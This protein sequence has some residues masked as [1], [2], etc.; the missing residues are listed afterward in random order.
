MP[1]GLT[2]A[3]ATYQR[4]ME[5]CLQGLN[6]RICLIYLGDLI[7]FSET[8]EEHLER[9]DI[10][11]KR[12]KDCNL[13]LA[14]EKYFFFK[15]KVNFLGHVVS[16]A[17]IET[18][19]E[20][21]NKV[22][23]WP[24]PSNS[25]ELRSFLAFAGYYRRFI[26]DFSKLIRPLSELLPPT[27]TKKGQKKL[28]VEWKWT[29]VEQQVFDNLKKILSSP[30]ILAFPDF[31]KP[32][33]VH[34]DAST[35]ALGAI[36]Y[37]EQEG[38]K[39]V[40]AYASRACTKA[41]QNYSAFKLEYLALKWAITDKF[42]DYLSGKHFIVLT[43][44]NPLTHIL[45][46]AK[47]DAT[48]QRWASQLGQFSFDIKYRAG[49]RN[50]D[51][52][53]MSRYPHEKLFDGAEECVRIDDKTVKAICSCI[54]ISPFID[55][56]PIATLN[57][58]ETIDVD[59][60][61]QVLAQKEVFEIRRSQRQGPLI[62]RW[63]KAV[64][65]RAVPNTYMT[66]DDL[67]MK[68]QFQ[69]LKIRRGIL[70]RNV[71][72]EDREVE[73]LVLPQCFKEEVLRGLHSEVGHP[74]RERT[75]R[76]VRERFY[77]PGMSRDI[78]QYVTKC[79]RCLRRKSSVHNRAPLVNVN[80]TYPLELVC[81]DYLTLEPSKGGIGNILVTDHYTKFAVAIPTK[82]Q[83]ARTTAE[84]FYNNF[85]IQYGIPTRLHSDQGANFESELIR[86]LC[87]I[88]NIKKSHTTPYHP[89]GN[90]GPERF[91][92]TLLDMLG[93]LEPHQK[94]N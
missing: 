40:I 34:T 84:A 33:E 24:I 11:M 19:P 22:Q 37:Q 91:N 72:D 32:F 17:G 8:F 67:T 58:L 14:P 82:N 4:L 28:K 93:T 83:T 77:W 3:P 50:A 59:D 13:K 38:I 65:D 45:T 55:M 79:D 52:D 30:P 20:K 64:I 89:Q 15:P 35:K 41:E 12:L 75:L 1:F 78:D 46:S 60:E 92:R 56:L 9:L 27:S 42:K 36:L 85:I 7:I 63:R 25:D 39:R 90:S 51:A 23:N 44:N 6:T 80:T 43:D 62:E 16:G 10:I 73:Q 48:C 26:R 88:M 54:V 18:D 94:R 49:L 81:F 86:E 87:N 76:L 57:K 70:F 61:S 29:E 47:L 2:N 66:K 74:G 69:K 68:K 53:A 21:I 71:K 31:N 5:E